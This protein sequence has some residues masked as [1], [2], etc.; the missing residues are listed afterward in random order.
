MGIPEKS[1]KPDSKGRIQLGKRTK[2][3]SSY[4]IIEEKNGC[5]ILMPQV[6]IPAKEAWLYQNREALEAVKK[7]L[8]DSASGKTMNRG[9][10][11]QYIDN[12]IE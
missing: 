10:F 3:I 11:A 4:K 9:S 2:G 6:E 5:I 1:L 12:E 7:G 8:E